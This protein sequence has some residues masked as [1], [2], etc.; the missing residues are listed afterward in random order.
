MRWTLN[1]LVHTLIVIFNFGVFALLA[2]LAAMAQDVTPEATPDMTPE[3]MVGVPCMV[4]AD[5]ANTVSVRVGPG[6]NR[7]SFIF[8][9]VDKEFEVLG[10]AEDDDGGLWWK[11]DRATVAPKKS[12]AEAWVAQEDVEATGDCEAVLDV[13]APP[14]IPISAPA[15]APETTPEASGENTSVEAITPQAGTWTIVYPA[16]ASGT[17]AKGSKTATLDL[18]WPPE[19]WQLTVS[20]GSLTYAGKNFAR[21]AANANLYSGQTQITRLGGTPIPARF[22]LRVT[23]ETEIAATLTFTNTVQDAACSFSV[24]ARMS[25]G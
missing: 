14:I 10:K 12:A 24:S 20:G 7:T 6:T 13:N 16:S 2:S 11:L 18:D 5:R 3:A 21:S 19:S 23:S 25:R 1:R 17:C 9:P 22:T 4:R 15:N 8:L